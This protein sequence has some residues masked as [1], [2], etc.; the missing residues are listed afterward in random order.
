[1][2]KTCSVGDRI[3]FGK[4]S[5]IVYNKTDSTVGLLCEK[6]LDE[7]R[8]YNPGYSDVT[9]ENCDL[10]KWLN[11]EFYNEFTDEEKSMITETTCNNKY[12]AEYKTTGGNDTKDKVFLLSIDEANKL[13][14]DILECGSWWWLRTTYDGVAWYVERDG[15]LNYD[16]TY[17]NDSGGVRPALNLEY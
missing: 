9:W 11:N 4:F 15:S 7:Q 3:S 14:K 1:M 5:W 17:I 10:R 16:F 8:K 6:L 13:S 2:L 12:N